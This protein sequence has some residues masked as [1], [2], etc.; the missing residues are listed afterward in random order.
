M[1]SGVSSFCGTLK[2]EAYY[3]R[4]GLIM[5]NWAGQFS[6]HFSRE[7]FIHTKSKWNL[8]ET[9]TLGSDYNDDVVDRRLEGWECPVVSKN[10]PFLSLRRYILSP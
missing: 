1:G 3:L 5:K 7:R 10:V 4:V 6:N 9:A 8:S 2:Y